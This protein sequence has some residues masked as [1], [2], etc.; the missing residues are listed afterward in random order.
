MKV[1]LWGFPIID[2]TLAPK[3]K[4]RQLGD[5]KPGDFVDYAY[6]GLP[7]IMAFG[8]TV[9]GVK[10]LAGQ[11]GTLYSF[12]D[13]EHASKMTFGSYMRI[14]GG[15][16]AEALGRVQALSDRE[17]RDFTITYATKEDPFTFLSKTIAAVDF[18]AA[19][20]YGNMYMTNQGKTVM[21]V[22]E[23]RHT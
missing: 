14:V 3:A 8:S 1:D 16:V 18:S 17:M 15:S 9:E 21:S 12:E 7:Q 22:T 20:G 13:F 2:W 19:V 5:F 23:I 11:N 6:L 10:F 4:R